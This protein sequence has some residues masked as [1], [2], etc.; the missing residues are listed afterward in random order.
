MSV[1]F[2]KAEDEA[3][4]VVEGVLAAKLS[5]LE[6]ANVEEE[7]HDYA[8]RMIAAV[9]IN[10]IELGCV[11]DVINTKKLFGAHDKLGK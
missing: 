10:F 4:S 2:I 6:A 11:L 3:L 7:V 9:A 1:E 5:V 8:K